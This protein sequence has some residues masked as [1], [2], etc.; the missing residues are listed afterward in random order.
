[1]M[2]NHTVITVCGQSGN[3]ELNVMLPVAAYA[4]L[5]SVELLANSCTNFARQCVNG[6][7]ATPKGPEMVSKG[8]MTCTNLVPFIGY[9]A[10]AKIA[11]KAAAT[12]R[13]IAEASALL[14]RCRACSA[15]AAHLTQHRRA[16]A[17]GGGRH[18][19]E[20]RGAG[21]DPGPGHDGGARAARQA[22]SRAQHPSA[23]AGWRAA[24]DDSPA[25]SWCDAQT[26]SRSRCCATRQLVVAAL[27]RAGSC[28]ARH[29]AAPY[30]PRTRHAP[31]R[32]ASSRWRTRCGRANPIR[33][34]RQRHA[35][36]SAT[37]SA[38]SATAAPA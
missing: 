34:Q 24:A 29:V 12:G 31:S 35:P 11:K 16:S 19:A 9:D 17:G 33:L 36:S 23:R 15:R 26:R 37:S 18:E 2:G 5:Q 32:C 22:V 38:A 25:A 30:A 21:Q 1:V 3:F 10:A 7:V 8:L 14:L 13:T 20:R 6:L 4:L 27:P 28:A